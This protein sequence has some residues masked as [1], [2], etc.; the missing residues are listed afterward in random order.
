MQ[1]TTL[2]KLF[3]K[4]NNHTPLLITTNNHTKTAN[5]VFFLPV[6]TSISV[7]NNIKNISMFTKKIIKSINPKN[8]RLSIY[9]LSKLIKSFI[10]LK[11]PQ[12][13]ISEG[14]VIILILLIC[15]PSDRRLLP[16][17][18]YNSLSLQF[19]FHSDRRL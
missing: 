15:T 4:V 5:T 12:V 8:S 3:I 9:N 18:S 17:Q 6:C 10:K 16:F 13:V 2:S 11:C 7:F 19:W 1:D 14:I